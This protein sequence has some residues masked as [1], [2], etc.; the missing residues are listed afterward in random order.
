MFK[1]PQLPSAFESLHCVF[2]FPETLWLKIIIDLG[3]FKWKELG[4]GQVKC[5]HLP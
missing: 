2:Y 1:L 5:S 3:V 4:G